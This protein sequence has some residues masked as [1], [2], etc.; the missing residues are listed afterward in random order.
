MFNKILVA[1]DDST[2]SRNIFDAALC[3]AKT[4]G[5]SLMLLH[6]LSS[7]DRDYPSPSLYS[8]LEYDPFDSIL[9]EA[10][11][12]RWQKFE[13]RGLEMLRSLTE[14]ATKAGVNTE[15]T[16]AE[17]NPAHIICDLA[18]T[19]SASLIFIG[20]RG[21][22]GVKEIFLGSV[23]NY[24]THHAPCSVFIWRDNVNPDSQFSQK[25]NAQ[26]TSSPS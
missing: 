4:T 19:W 20:S 24:V 22:T 13:Q 25:N 18:Q 7:D 21:L 3:L 14:E 5:A 26:L 16:Q 2:T 23:S 17:G 10:Y 1:I 15:F 8:G 12:E 11:Q 6:V 9:I